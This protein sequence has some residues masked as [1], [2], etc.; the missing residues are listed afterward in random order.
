MAA[1]VLFGLSA[2]EETRHNIS[3]ALGFEKPDFN[4]SEVLTGE[5]LAI[6]PDFDL[7]P[8]GSGEELYNPSA[9]SGA[10]VVAAPQP[11]AIP[12]QGAYPAQGTYPGA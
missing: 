4:E 9:N 10:P 5:P 11:P 8:P 3:K 2:C 1:V 7:R 6:P 12:V